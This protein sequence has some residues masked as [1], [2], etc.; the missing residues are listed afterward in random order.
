MRIDQP[1]ERQW[2][3]QLLFNNLGAMSSGPA[4][5]LGLMA[6]NLRRTESSQTVISVTAGTEQPLRS[7]CCGKF[8]LDRLSLVQ[9]LAK[10]S[11]INFAFSKSL[12]ARL[13]S[14]LFKGPIL[15]P[16]TGF[17][18]SAIKFQC[19]AE[20]LTFQLTFP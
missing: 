16:L 7:L 18:A 13:P 5:T 1:R 15:F 12:T 3:A 11:F 20:D 17:V 8:P 4:D 6:F 10:K 2:Q 9:I 19:A 14:S